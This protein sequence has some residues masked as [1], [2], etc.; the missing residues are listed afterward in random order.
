MRWW[1]G[2]TLNT[3][4]FGAVWILSS[5]F[6]PASKQFLFQLCSIPLMLLFNWL[7]A[8]GVSLA[9]KQN[10]PLFAVSLFNT[11]LGVG[12]SVLGGW[13][14]LHQSLNWKQALGAAIILFGVF[15]LNYKQA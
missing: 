5:K 9:Y 6:I 8:I 3:V 13:L 15:V 1:M 10:V 14:F 12:I 7:Y 2:I 4:Y 11:V